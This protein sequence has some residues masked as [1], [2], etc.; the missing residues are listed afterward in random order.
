MG[1]T[2]IE[3]NTDQSEIEQLL[4]S[5]DRPGDYCV[6]SK[7]VSPMPLLQVDEMGTVAFPVQEAQV[8]SLIGVAQR[9]PYGKG[10]D[11]VLDTSVRDCWQIDSSAFELGGQGWAQ[12]FKVIMQQVSDGP[13]VPLRAAGGAAVQAA[14]L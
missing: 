10:P 12:S 3:Y 11:T 4:K 13:R 14:H 8:R 6:H 1:F 7:L 9:A 5:L 2:Q